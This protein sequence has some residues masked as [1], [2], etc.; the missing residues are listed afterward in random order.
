MIRWLQAAHVRFFWQPPHIDLDG[1]RGNQTSASIIILERA[2]DFKI[3]RFHLR[4]LRHIFIQCAPVDLQ[5]HA[6]R[7]AW[8]RHIDFAANARAG[9]CGRLILDFG[10]CDVSHSQ[11][12]GARLEYLKVNELVAHRVHSWHCYTAFLPCP[13]WTQSCK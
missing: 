10:E 4:Q 1:L 5:L 11:F 2:A 6:F 12:A 13:S 9:H 7:L 3:L 8:R